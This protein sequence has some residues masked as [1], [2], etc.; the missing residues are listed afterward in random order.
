M[1]DL[2]S[3][4]YKHHYNVLISKYLK[5]DIKG[6]NDLIK[7]QIKKLDGTN[8][9]KY[10]VNVNKKINTVLQ[11]KDNL[12]K[13]QEEKL[14]QLEPF[15]STQ[16]I[17]T[18]KNMG[19]DKYLD[20]LVEPLQKAKDDEDIYR[21]FHDYLNFIQKK[22][23]KKNHH[24]GDKLHSQNEWKDIHK[25]KNPNKVDYSFS[26][27]WNNKHRIAL[28]LNDGTKVYVTQDYIDQYKEGKEPHHGRLWTNKRKKNKP[29][30][31]FESTDEEEN[32][33][34]KMRDNQSRVPMTINER[35]AFNKLVD[36]FEKKFLRLNNLLDKAESDG[37]A[38][39]EFEEIE[40]LRKDYS[41]LFTQLTSSK[42]KVDIDYYIKLSKQKV[43]DKAKNIYDKYK[44]GDIKINTPI[45]IKRRKTGILTTLTGGEYI[46]K[47]PGPTGPTGPAGPDPTGPTGPAGPDPTG[48]TGPAEPEPTEPAE[49]EP[50]E[51]GPTAFKE[52][53]DEEM[54]KLHNDILNNPNDSDKVNK[55]L[56][57]MKSKD[58]KDRHQLIVK[59][60]DQAGHGGKSKNR[61][62]TSVNYAVGKFTKNFEKWLKHHGQ[63]TPEELEKEKE[64][65]K[66]E[67]E[68]IKKQREAEEQEKG[69]AL[70]EKPPDVDVTGKKFK[71]K[72]VE[73]EE[74]LTA[75][76]KYQKLKKQIKDLLSS[77]NVENIDEMENENDKRQAKILE[78][79][80]KKLL[81]DVAKES[82]E[83]KQKDVTTQEALLR[84]GDYRPHFKNTTKKSVEE[85]ISKSSEQQIRDMKNWYIFDIP[86]SYTGQGTALD[87]PLIKQNDAR[88]ELL[89][90]G[91]I[92][93]DFIQSY[94][95]KEGVEENKNFY[96][97]NNI[98]NPLSVRDGL[99]M[100]HYEETE[101]EFLQK[102]NKGTNG[103]FSQYQTK[104]ELN[105]FNNIYQKPARFFQ[106]G[107]TQP[108]LINNDGIVHNNNSWINNPNYFYEGAVIS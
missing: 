79:E 64:K 102:F 42:K 40:K 31:Y 18:M 66:A 46:P 82:E 35:E 75:T 21:N 81:P 53:S 108:Q 104:E 15:L 93:K 86:S 57:Q 90:S 17:N 95:I 20:E 107:Y 30:S 13:K 106:G 63:L 94:N 45:D 76:Q 50:T 49:P 69:E 68:A 85:E 14:R 103:L 25:D 54:I 96:K 3:K 44:K 24:I 26:N 52:L 19:I 5:G 12:T 59:L 101:E 105:Q 27:N 8:D 72:K 48:P 7:E 33:D 51:P 91:N 97:E 22:D 16:S 61:L 43:T 88:E 23:N 70:T 73:E 58:K 41:K 83:K 92:Y 71:V 32:I 87:N 67:E 62:Q 78:E 1:V 56:E 55:Y 34:N 9:R 10:I 84:Q 37:L 89:Y 38:G 11:K 2:N 65:K 28:Y 47:G 60:N 4:E 99:N 39:R 98:L 74:T 29:D 6:M 80:A 36:P 77:A 100:I